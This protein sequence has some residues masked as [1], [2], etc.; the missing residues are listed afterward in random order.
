MK[1]V[2]EVYKEGCSVV[3]FLSRK[4]SVAVVSEASL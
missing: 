1:R 3:L 2:L 4:V